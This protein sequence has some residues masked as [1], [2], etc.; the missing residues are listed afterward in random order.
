MAKEKTP[1][2]PKPE[3]VVFKD[4]EKATVIQH[5]EKVY[6]N[7]S[8]S[9]QAKQRTNKTNKRSKESDT[10][11]YGDDSASAENSEKN[12]IKRKKRRGSTSITAS[13]ILSLLIIALCG[14]LIFFAVTKTLNLSNGITSVV[15]A[16]CVLLLIA[17]IVSWILWI[18]E[19]INF[20]LFLIM[21]VLVL[22][23]LVYST[24]NIAIDTNSDNVNY[25]EEWN[26]EE[27]VYEGWYDRW[28]YVRNP[29]G[30]VTIERYY[31]DDTDIIIPSHINGNEV[32]E[33]GTALFR[34][35][36]KITNIE[37]PDT[38]TSI[39]S[40]A[41]NGCIS[42]E[43]ITLPF[44]GAT[45]S[46]NYNT[47]FGYI[48]GTDSYLGGTKTSQV[49]V[50]E[51]QHDAVYD[52]AGEPIYNTYYI[53]TS[54][55]RV[56]IMGY[57]IAGGAFNGCEG[58]TEIEMSDNV[59]VIGWGAFAYCNNLTSIE[60]PNSVTSVGEGAFY[61]CSRLT[62]IEIPYSVI[63]IGDYVFRDCSALT[64]IE[65]P[66]SVTSIL[67]Y[68]FWG[69][70]SLTSITYKGTKAQW[71]AIDKGSKWDYNTGNYTIHCSDGDIVKS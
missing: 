46:G 23:G 44:V 54:L 51:S 14:C 15:I 37:I 18:K 53:P 21:W 25:H 24:V 47:H 38:V 19:K 29:Y 6:I 57:S 10:F 7:K 33:L 65:I 59:K 16:L 64:S 12:Y 20:V 30:E 35:P 71:N 68:A 22:L 17:G 4:V 8:D 34:D 36:E 40:G 26:S 55:R 5:A 43:S 28:Y 63:S 62:S 69:C 48:F 66:N 52:D 13:V 1:K 49:C 27:G 41:F 31:G 3:K 42:L 11:I 45:K 32:V 58:L 39:E 2:S 56:K 9:D 70:S 61:D 50:D 60:I 67:G